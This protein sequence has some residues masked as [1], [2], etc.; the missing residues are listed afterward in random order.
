MSAI[1][2]VLANNAAF[3][4]AY[5]DR[6]PPR[7]PRR[8]L[9]V[10]AC[11]DSRLDIYRMLGLAEGEAHVIRNAGGVVTQDTIRSLV[12][13][14]RIG[15]TREVMLMHNTECGMLTF[16]DAELRRRVESET[17]AEVPFAF[18]AFSDLEEQVRRSVARIRESPLLVH[19]DAVR[20]FVYEVR[21]GRLREVR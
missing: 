20:G 6:D 8:R 7:P 14:Q 4:A 1:D 21:T 19:R 16:R 9:A 11:M 12:V 5:E 3:A 2:D 17:G 13:S 10:V 18:Q 15:G